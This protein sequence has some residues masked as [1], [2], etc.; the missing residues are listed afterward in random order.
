MAFAVVEVQSYETLPIL[1]ELFGIGKVSA[2]YLF[3]FNQYIT[4]VYQQL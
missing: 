4:F 1:Q 2:Q 3:I